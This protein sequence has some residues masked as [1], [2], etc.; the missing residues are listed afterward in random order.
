MGPVDSANIDPASGSAFSPAATVILARD[1]AGELQIYLLKRSPQS[2]FMAGHFVFPGGTVDPADRDFE[3][4]K[5]HI[6]TDLKDISTRLGGELADAEVLAYA[7]AAVR[8]T[9][10]EAGV[11]LAW[12]ARQSDGDLE[13]ICNL[14]LSPGLAKDWF[15]QLATKE[16]WR[17]TLSDLC[18]WSHWLTPEL[19]PRRFDTR[20]FLAAMPPG[21]R[22]RPDERETIQGLWISPSKGL[23]GNLAGVI[24]LSPPTVIT[25]HELLQYTNLHELTTAARQRTWGNPLRPRLV[26]LA[27]G[28][29]IVEPWDPM[30]ACAE[31]K[32]DPA[33]LAAAVLPVGVPFSKLWHDAG[34]WKPVSL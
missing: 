23:A 21:Q 13:R 12:R 33:E 16:G 11:L 17:L 22:C 15:V 5:T 10:E 1:F 27:E 2:G 31:I 29:V 9:V 7:V 4:W 14:R 19:M 26:P 34:I 25:L 8:E 30:Y 18:P 20:F 28:A 32:I 3:F 6:D 24:P